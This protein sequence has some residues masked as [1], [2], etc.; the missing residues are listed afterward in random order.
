M[1]VFVCVILII[2]TRGLI[3]T[4]NKFMGKRQNIKMITHKLE[5]KV[6]GDV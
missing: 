2:M 5:E 1:Y 4:Y 6:L 3:S